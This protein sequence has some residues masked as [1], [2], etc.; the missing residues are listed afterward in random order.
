[1]TDAQ[2]AEMIALL[3]AIDAKLASI[4][5]STQSSAHLQGQMANRR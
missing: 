3:K 4:A 5:A 2:A 1:M